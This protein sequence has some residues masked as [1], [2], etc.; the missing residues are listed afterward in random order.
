L[1]EKSSAISENLTVQTVT[2]LLETATITLIRMCGAREGQ[3][4]IK[5]TGNIS[6]T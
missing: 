3:T 2:A 5:K 6:L 1:Y 4:V